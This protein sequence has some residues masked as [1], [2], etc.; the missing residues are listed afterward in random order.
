MNYRIGLTDLAK[1][2]SGSDASIPRTG[3]D[4][5]GLQVKI[6]KYKPRVLAFNGKTAAE[7]FLR[8]DVDYGLQQAQIGETKVF[9]LPSTSGA[10]GRWWD[11]KCWQ[12][13]SSRIKE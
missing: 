13:L 10:A 7:K 4:T 12:E 2:D 3:Y 11:V 1:S 9:V 8:Q 6:K 5:D